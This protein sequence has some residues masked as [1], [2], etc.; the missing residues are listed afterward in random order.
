MHPGSEHRFNLKGRSLSL[1]L[2]F[3]VCSGF[4]VPDYAQ[5][6]LTERIS[7]KGMLLVARND[8]ADPRFRH[9]VL[10]IIQHNE[11]GATGLMINHPTR[12]LLSKLLPEIPELTDHSDTIFIGGPLTDVPLLLL[13]DNPPPPHLESVVN[14]VDTI[15]MSM[16]YTLIP[17]CLETIGT[18][19]RAFTG[20]ASWAPGQLEA[21][22]ADRVWSL[23][24]ADTESVFSDTTSTLWDRLS[25]HR[26][27]LNWV[28]DQR[29]EATQIIAPSIT[30]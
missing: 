14:V 16:N 30:L 15:Y 18:Q 7:L 28:R 2:L 29:P 4:S 1:L 6:T 22:L 17:D 25:N 5:S 27:N 11:D 24:T 9:S 8:I 20:I 12:I 19:I 26:D 21:E 13:I 3:V 10:L 23:R